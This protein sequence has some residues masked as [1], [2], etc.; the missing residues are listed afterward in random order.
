MHDIIEILFFARWKDFIFENREIGVRG[1]RKIRDVRAIPKNK[2]RTSMTRTPSVRERVAQFM[3][4]MH[5]KDFAEAKRIRK[6]TRSMCSPQRWST[7]CRLWLERNPD[8]ALNKWFE[9]AAAD[10]KARLEGPK[11]Y[12]ATRKWTPEQALLE[13]FMANRKWWQHLD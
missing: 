13:Q 3:E 9:Q 7:E 11:S 8:A 5:R 12:M 10:L 1:S 6:F 2:E 4:A